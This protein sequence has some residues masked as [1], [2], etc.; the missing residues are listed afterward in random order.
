MCVCV[1]V[2][3]NAHG[4]VSASLLALSRSTLHCASHSHTWLASLANGEEFIILN[5]TKKPTENTVAT[6]KIGLAQAVHDVF[7]FLPFATLL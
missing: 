5:A 2:L 1:C 3:D 6:N 4:R 7:C